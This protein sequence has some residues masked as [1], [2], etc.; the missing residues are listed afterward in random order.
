MKSFDTFINEY[1]LEVFDIKSKLLKMSKPNM[2]IY[3]IKYL[4]QKYNE[5]EKV[6]NNLL[7]EFQNVDVFKVVSGNEYIIILTRINNNVEVHFN[8]FNNVDFFDKTHS[9]SV[10]IKVF[11][12]IFNIVY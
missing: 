9:E 11:S 10:P 8:N 4:E 7:S 12:E 3:L 5:S 1:L 2:K 6:Y